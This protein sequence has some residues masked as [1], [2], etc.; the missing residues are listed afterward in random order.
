MNF[1][2]RKAS[3]AKSKKV[4]KRMKHQIKK[5]LREIENKNSQQ[6]IDK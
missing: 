4:K 6:F 1:P 3:C 2:W 5:I